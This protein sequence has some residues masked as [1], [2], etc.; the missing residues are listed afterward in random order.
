MN[1]GEI[2]TE[3]LVRAG[4]DTTSAWLSEAFLNDWINQSHR[5]AAGYKPWPFSEARLSTT[6]TAVEEWDFEGLKADSVRILKVGDKLFEKLNFED[7]LIYKENSASG[8]DRVYTDFNSTL[9]INTASGQSGTLTVYGQYMPADIPDGDGAGADDAVT[10]F[11]PQGD[12]GNQAIIEKVLGNIANRESKPEIAQQHF[13]VA[14]KL[15]EDLWKRVGDEQYG[16]KTTRD[17]GGMFRRFNVLRGGVN[18]NINRRDQF[19]FN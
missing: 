6:Y 12:E 14:L 10:V 18:D 5:W 13:S 11:T 17:R 9:F 3:V 7:Y 2:R 16:Y 19:P 4:R 1:R 15:L 8:S